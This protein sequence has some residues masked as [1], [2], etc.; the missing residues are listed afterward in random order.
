VI[1]YILKYFLKQVSMP[2][3]LHLKLFACF[4][5]PYLVLKQVGSVAYKLQLFEDAQFSMPQLKLAVENH[6]VEKELPVNVQG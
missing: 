1:G 5:G 2:T 3:R 6:H 4:Y